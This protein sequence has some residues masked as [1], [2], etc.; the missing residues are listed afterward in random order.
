MLDGHRT[1]ALPFAMSTLLSEHFH[2]VPLLSLAWGVGQIGLPF[3]ESGAISILGFQLPIQA[4]STIVASVAP[5]LT[6]AGSMRLRVEE[7][8]PSINAAESQ[9]AALGTLISLARGYTAPLGENA[10]NRGLKDLLKSAEVSQNHNRV[11]VKATVSGS[12]FAGLAADASQAD[13]PDAAPIPAN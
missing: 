12:L 7:I 5:E 1:A 11:T 6:H 10:A 9:A 13:H 2:D 8:A 3:N 4:D